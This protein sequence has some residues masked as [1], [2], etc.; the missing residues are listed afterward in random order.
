MSHMQL[1]ED[2]IGSFL[3]LPRNPF[4]SLHLRLFTYEYL[5]FFPSIHRPYLY[6]A[7]VPLKSINGE[8]ILLVRPCY[9]GPYAPWSS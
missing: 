4:D 1:G 8:S 2:D 7:S 3:P 9:L 6:R 5:K